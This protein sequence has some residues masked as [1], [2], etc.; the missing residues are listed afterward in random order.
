MVEYEVPTWNQTYEMMLNVAHAIRQSGFK[1]DIIIGVARGGLVPSRV[2]CDLLQTPVLGMI[3]IEF[4][5]DVGQAGI[6][7][8]LKQGLTLPVIG[9]KV[10]LADD[11]ADTGRSLRLAKNY[12]QEQG[13]SEVKVACLY[14]KPQSITRPD[15]FDRETRSWVVFP[16]D[17]KET[18]RKIVSHC[19]GKRAVGREIG[20]LVKAGLPRQ[21]ADR[22]LEDMQ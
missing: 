6:E 7:P 14:A 11:I 3:E 17:A 8:R 22:F 21:F 15:Y 16:W 13:P 1:P 5:V 18:V 20:K 4:Y 12:I 10:L 9:K 2:L 19:R